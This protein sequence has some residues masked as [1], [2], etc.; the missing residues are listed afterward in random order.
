MVAAALA[1]LV[2]T[3][4]P[5]DPAGAAAAAAAAGAP[6]EWPHLLNVLVW[7]PIAAGVFV[8]FMPRQLL[9]MLRGF[10][11][12][13]MGVTF[14]ASLWLLAVPMTAGWHFQYIHAWIPSIGVRY[15]VAG[16][17]DQPVAHPAH[18]LHHAHR[19]VRGV[20]IDPA[21]ASRS[22]ASRSSSSRGR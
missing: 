9:G 21:R 16:G 1:L 3:L 22:C 10:T 4:W 17:R 20:R 12:A 19:G 7:L 11:L 15:H 2:Q 8:L 13:V 18:H 6:T 5:E 14:V